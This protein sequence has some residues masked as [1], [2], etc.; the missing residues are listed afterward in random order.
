M[1][2]DEPARNARPTQN[3][4]R[5]AASAPAR[6][7]S[8]SARPRPAQAG[9][10]PRPAQGASRSAAPR[11]S[12]ARA[13]YKRK[14]ANPL[15]TLLY[16]VVAVAVAFALSFLVRSYVFDLVRIGGD[17]MYETLLGGDVAYVDLLAYSESAT[18]QRGDVVAVS[19]PGENGLLL[20]RIV[21]LP[22]E[23]VSLTGGETLVDGEALYEP[24]VSL[25]TYDTFPTMTLPLG[26]YYLLCDNRTKTADSRDDRVSIVGRAQIRGKGRYVIWPLNHL[27]SF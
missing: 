11:P 4:A 12:K 25:K 1:R 22:G 15:V 7:A 8:A 20:R 5:P 24:Y 27:G 18:P 13:K 19:L 17:E 6:P 26:S 2:T 9:A 23:T 21:A 16:W 3:R 14:R 10:K